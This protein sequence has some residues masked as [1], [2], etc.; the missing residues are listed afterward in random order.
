MTEFLQFL[1]I[2]AFWIF[3]FHFAF[4]EGKIFGRIGDWLRYRPISKPLTE[5][6]MCMASV[7][8]TAFYLYFMP[9]DIVMWIVFVVCLCGLNYILN[10]I[11]YE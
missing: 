5:C 6:P 2:A 4:K 10:S 3:G 9:F 11:G 7:H 8:G 1:F